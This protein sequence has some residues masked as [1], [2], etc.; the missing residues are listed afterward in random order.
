MIKSFRHKGLQRFFEKGSK[1]GIQPQHERRLRLM[2][3]RLDDATN[4]ADMDAAG[5]KLH[6]LKGD[7]KGQWAKMEAQRRQTPEYRINNM[8]YDMSQ[9]DWFLSRV[10]SSDTYAQN[11]YAAMCN[12]TFQKQDVWLILKD[13]YWSC[14]WRSAGGI[15][16][17]L[18]DKGGDYMDWYCSGIG[19]GLGNGDTDGTR[20]FVS[21]GTVTDE[22]ATDLALLGWRVAEEPSND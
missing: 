3:S 5:W 9:A 8:E 14:T 20:N 10:R 6:A 12:S 1:A 17:D 4:A 21:E 11:L 2:L 13:A 16:A 19:D 22:I 7:L 15:V 18:Q